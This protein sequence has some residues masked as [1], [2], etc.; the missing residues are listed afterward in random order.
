MFPLFFASRAEDNQRRTVLLFS[1]LAHCGF[2]L[3]CRAQLT[4]QAVGQH[5]ETLVKRNLL[6]ILFGNFGPTLSLS[7]PQKLAEDERPV[8][9]FDGVKLWKRSL[10]ESRAG[11]PA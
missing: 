1:D 10:T 3:I 8:A 9:L 2:H 5:L 4:V 6:R 11:S 7:R